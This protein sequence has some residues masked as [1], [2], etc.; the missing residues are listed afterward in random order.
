MKCQDC[1]YFKLSAVDVIEPEPEGD[2][3]N[4]FKGGTIGT[5]HVV[6]PIFIKSQLLGA[7]PVVM[8]DDFC[9]QFKQK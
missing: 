2:Y 7:F 1:K 9:G 5:C 8:L 3:A 4:G 6:P